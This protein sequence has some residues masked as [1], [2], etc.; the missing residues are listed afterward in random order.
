MPDITAVLQSSA[1]FVALVALAVAI[2]SLVIARQGSRRPAAPRASRVATADTHVDGLLEQQGAR[3]DGL[4][5]ALRDLESVVQ[6]I[7]RDLRIV[8][9]QLGGVDSELRDI[10]ARTVDLE[11]RGRRAVQRVG[12]V[13]FNPFDDT[14][15]NQSF[16]LALLDDDDD[17]IVL[18][19][20]HSRQS[21]RLYLKPIIGGRCEAPLSGEEAEAVA[22]AVAGVHRAE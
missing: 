5:R 1:P 19:S 13:R 18:S 3:V 8:G 16:A 7:D 15:S 10:V 11:V 4:D 17:G 2:V 12:L 6:G 9:G 20:L 22:V 14:G 21:T